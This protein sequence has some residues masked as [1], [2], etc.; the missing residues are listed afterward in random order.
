M[1]QYVNTISK[2]PKF[3]NKHLLECEKYI[4][5]KE[6]LEALKSMLYKKSLGMMILLKNILKN[7]GLR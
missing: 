5:E 1:N 4:T 6:L 2:F 3:S 7:L